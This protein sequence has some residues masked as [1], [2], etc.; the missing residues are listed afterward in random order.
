MKKLFNLIL[1]VTTSLLFLS[2][3]KEKYPGAYPYDEIVFYNEYEL[4]KNTVTERDSIS[5]VFLKIERWNQE[6]Y[7]MELWVDNEEIATISSTGYLTGK[8]E[9]TVTIYARVMGTHGVLEDS[10]KYRVK[11]FFKEYIKRNKDY[12]KY[13]GIDRNNDNGIS[14]AEVKETE[15][16]TKFINSNFLLTIA[17]YMP[18]LKEVRV[19]ADTT[20]RILDLSN[21]KFKQLAIQDY[22]FE[23]ALSEA[24]TYYLDKW[25]FN[26][27]KNIFLKE[28]KLNNAIEHLTI[29]YLPGIKTLDL[30]QYT[31]LKTVI[32]KI[33][34][35]H[36]SEWYELELILPENIENVSLFQT[37]IN[38][39]YTYPNLKKLVYNFQGYADISKHKRI[40]LNKKQLPNLKIIDVRQGIR[41]LDISTFQ[42]SEID[43]AYITTDT[44]FISQSMYD[45][46]YSSGKTIYAEHYIIK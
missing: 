24:N 43:T 28:L 11:D 15:V 37:E 41:N 3:E 31:N 23:Y 39:D 27:Y 29:W 17:P 45:E 34:T 44:I 16:I 20:S 21:Y 6:L 12:L 7:P 4:Y 19:N 38:L 10:I 14:P 35:Y 42:A 2:C 13:L 5:V 40:V 8:K 18:N 1:L 9:G 22:C 26:K 33:A 36:D 25:Y 32:R 46:R 30:R